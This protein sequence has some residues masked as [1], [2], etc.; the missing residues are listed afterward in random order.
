MGPLVNADGDVLT[1]DALPKAAVV[2][3][4]RFT[5]TGDVWETFRLPGEKGHKG[6]RLLWAAG[7]EITQA[8]F[9]AAFVAATVTGVDPGD[10]PAAGGTAVA[11]TGTNLRGVSGVT[12]GGAA[13]TNVVVVSDE[14]VTCTTPAH[15]AGAVDVVV[16]DDAADVT[17]DDAFTYA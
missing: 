15:A 16:A 9:D 2:V 4:D 13:A 5:V 17:V 12:F 8:E 7:T 10:G 14:Q 3:E 11:I 6:K 1:K